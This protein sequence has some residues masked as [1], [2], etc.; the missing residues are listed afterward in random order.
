MEKITIQQMSNLSGLSVHTLRYYEKIGMLKSVGRDSHGYRQY[1]EL[2]IAWIQF[3]I[4]LRATGMPIKDMKRFSEL[5]SEGDITVSKRREL[6]ELHQRNV[7]DQIKELE[8]NL[9]QISTKISYY[10][11][12]EGAALALKKE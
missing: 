6:L 8:E 2:D 7:L 1:S 3:L 12:L 10:K 5:R 4:R 11:E 9:K